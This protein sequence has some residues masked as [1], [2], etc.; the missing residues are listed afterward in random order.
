VSARE[1]LHTWAFRLCDEVASRSRDPNTKV[2]AVILRPDKTIASSGY[3]GFPRGVL[4]SP[5]LYADRDIKLARTIHAELN[6][7]LFSKEN[8]EGCQ[9]FLTPFPPCSHCAAAIIQSGIKDVF[10]GCD[11]KDRTKWVGSLE[12]SRSLFKEAGVNLILVM[13]SPL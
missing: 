6:A 4:D 7:L 2:G 11:G 1:S 9:L 8:L 3:N 13:R 10:V 5:E 12:Q